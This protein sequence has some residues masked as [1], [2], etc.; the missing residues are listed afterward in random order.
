MGAEAA[1]KLIPT[2]CTVR[3]SGIVSAPVDQVW[4]VVKKVDFSWRKDVSECTVNGNENELCTRTVKYGVDGDVKQVK[5]LRGLNSYDHTATWEMLSSEP[6][7]SYSSA[8]YS[9]QLEAITMTSET[10]V[11][12][13]TVYSDD[14]TVQQTQDQKYKLRDGI[15]NLQA[16]FAK[17]ADK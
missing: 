7:V 8:R 4:A 17:K 16:K 13:T 6:A 3:E 14:A 9:V 2:S 1:A 10:L 5:A 11:I 15:S 12:F